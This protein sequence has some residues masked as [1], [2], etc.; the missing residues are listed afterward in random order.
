M[1]LKGH[2]KHV[3]S[4]DWSP[5]GHN[6]VTG[7]EDHTLRIWDIR[8]AE[9]IYTVP[10][11]KNIVSQVKY[12]KAGDA[13]QSDSTSNASYTFGDDGMDMEK[14]DGSDI[15]VSTGDL[16]KT[17]NTA[18]PN[19]SSNRRTRRQVLNGSF[20]VS[21][22]YDGT[23]KIWTDGDFKPLKSLT[24]LEGKITCSDVS[25]GNIV[26]AFNSLVKEKTNREHE[27]WKIH[28]HNAL[29]QDV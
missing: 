16:E 11:H 1:V 25:G 22:S 26:L 24:G 29:R 9:S 21:S 13:F 19:S 15:D 14:E 3:L 2:V 8:K 10:A 4:L 18:A 28:C 12:F 20:L 5:N 27:R 6:L 23:C 17:E 7:S